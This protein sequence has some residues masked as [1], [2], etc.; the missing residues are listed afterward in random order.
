M[1]RMVKLLFISIFIACQHC[2]VMI[3]SAYLT[4]IRVSA[5]IFINKITTKL[6]KSFILL[7][8]EKLVLYIVIHWRINSLPLGRYGK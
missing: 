4:K 2:K 3:G 5:M 6:N 7:L 1:K 8:M